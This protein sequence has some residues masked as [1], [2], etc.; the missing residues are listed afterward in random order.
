MINDAMNQLKSTL[1][2]Q[3][4]RYCLPSY[5]DIH[6]VS[7]S[8]FVP[9]AHFDRMM[10]GSELCTGAALDGVPQD[11]SDE[12]VS[13]H[14]DPES[15]IVLPWRKDVAWFASDLWCEG[16]PF[17]PCS[18]NIF[19]SVLAQAADMGYCLLYTSPSPR[20]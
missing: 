6:G 2:Q 16:K 9:I 8:K 13:S 15:L 3:G 7:K 14:P 12:E 18:R 4:V 5:V 10:S 1:E 11:V 17:E 20:D 19:K